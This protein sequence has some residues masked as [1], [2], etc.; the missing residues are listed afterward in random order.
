[1][2]IP[3]EHIFFTICDKYILVLAVETFVKVPVHFC[4]IENSTAWTFHWEFC[5]IK[6]K[7][8]VGIS[9]GHEVSTIQ[10]NS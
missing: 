9:A 2:H 4:Q 10:P 8:P 5:Y 7:N 1:M 6:K 3:K